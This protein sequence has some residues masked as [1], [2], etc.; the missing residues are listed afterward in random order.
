MPSS[1]Q[2]RRFWMIRTAIGKTAKRKSAT[3]YHTRGYIQLGLHKGPQGQWCC[4]AYYSTPALT[5]ERCW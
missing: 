1:S 3:S 2:L 5:M 4:E